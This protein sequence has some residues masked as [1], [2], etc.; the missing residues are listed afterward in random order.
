MVGLGIERVQLRAKSASPQ[1][2]FTYAEAMSTA[3]GDRSCQ[4]ILNDRPDIALLAG[5]DGCHL[6]QEDLSVVRA[7]QLLPRP[8]VLGLSTHNEAQLEA[9]NAT[10][11]DY[12]AIGP[13]F[14]TSTKRNADPVVGL[15]EFTR[16]RKLTAKPVVA[17]G[18]ITRDNARSVLDAGADSV[19]IIS[20]LYRGI[21]PGCT[22]DALA[23]LVGQN[24]EDILARI[25]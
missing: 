9:G 14:A 20:D 8:A 23:R 19:A 24:L 10:D 4:L 18:G 7:R 25:L 2:T 13:V 11:A 12:L 17:I 21:E 22:A 16:L 15:M 6:G 1:E 5:F 3:R